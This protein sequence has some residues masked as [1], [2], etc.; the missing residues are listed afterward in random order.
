[1]R[2]LKLTTN[3]AH[4]INIG[5]VHSSQS[6]FLAAVKEILLRVADVA[7]AFILFLTMHCNFWLKYAAYC[8]CTCSSKY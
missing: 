3:A 1:V 6:L 5:P 7:D 4:I 2:S 8:R